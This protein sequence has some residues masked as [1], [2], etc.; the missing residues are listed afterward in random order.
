M[1]KQEIEILLSPEE[2]FDELI[3]YEA[4]LKGVGMKPGEADFVHL[5]RRSID[6]RGRNPQ[7]RLRA[8]VYT[9]GT[10]AELFGPWFIIQMLNQKLLA[11]SS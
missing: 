2:A 4:I 8:E 5:K 10:P 6:A 11:Y 3:R 7:I 1:L 9:N